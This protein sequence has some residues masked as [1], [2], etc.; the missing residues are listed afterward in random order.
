MSL[1]ESLGEADDLIN[2]RLPC[3]L[4]PF[5][6][7]AR[8]IFCLTKASLFLTFIVMYLACQVL[9]AA[10]DV[11]DLHCGILGSFSCGMQTLSSTM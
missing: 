8:Q 2:R 9:V 4:Y 3:H 11:S 1:R 7:A 5:Q 10:C 6:Q